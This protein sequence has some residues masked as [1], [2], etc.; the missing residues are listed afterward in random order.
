MATAERVRTAVWLGEE[1]G[2]LANQVAARA[3][4]NITMAGGP[5]RG[6]SAAIAADL[7]AQPADDLRSILLEADVDLILLMSVGDFGSDPG[8]VDTTAI[9]TAHRRGVKIASLEPVPASA[10]EIAQSR[11]KQQVG[12]NSLHDLI[13]LC[14]LDRFSRAHRD[15]ADLLDLYGHPSVLS[16]DATCAP[17]EGTLGGRLLSALDL[18]HAMLGEPEAVNAVYTPPASENAIIP[19]PGDDL[20]SLRGS[21]SAA[22]RLADGRGATVL[23]SDQSSD[24]YRDVTLIGPKGRLQIS[25]AGS[26]WSGEPA[27]ANEVAKEQPAPKRARGVA[28]DAPLFHPPQPEAPAAPATD[29]AEAIAW[30]LRR[31]LDPALPPERP[32]DL[33]S[34]L[35][36]AQ[37]ALLSARTGQSE[38]ISTV[39]RMAGVS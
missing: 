23:A 27:P 30:S 13:R 21:I 37:T 28:K 33:P 24:W 8:G 31:M 12:T 1:Q 14:P 25:D 35:A 3:G 6:R 32:T 2:F 7:S 22:V 29:A 11:W 34:L 38:S 19:E 4:L 39:R 5:V 20:R 17:A 9:L 36:T 16:I 10:I 15:A 26:R 18:I